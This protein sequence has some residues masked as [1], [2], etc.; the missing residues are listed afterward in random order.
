MWVVRPFSEVL[1]LRL[2]RRVTIHCGRVTDNTDRPCRLRTVTHKFRMADDIA[3]TGLNRQIRVT[4]LRDSLS[5]LC[6]R[7]ERPKLHFICTRSI[8]SSSSRYEL[9]DDSIYAGR[10]SP[11]C[12]V[13]EQHCLTLAQIASC[14]S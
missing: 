5:S 10:S 13:V 1:T 4:E 12:T 7:Q 8:H 6:L 14:L 11:M 3:A 9:R 2:T